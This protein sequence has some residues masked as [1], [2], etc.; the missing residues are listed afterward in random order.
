MILQR[1]LLYGLIAILVVAPL[2]FGSVQRGASLRL[3]A[4]CLL[5]GVVWMAWRT[6]AGLPPLPWRDPALAA[7]ALIALFAVFQIV[8]WPQ[9]V[10][11]TI[12][13]KAVSLREAY[14]P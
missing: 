4:G 10:L 7:G 2:P 9:P 12:S 13:P 14:E 6:R 3:C 5:L 1:I 8:P 11:Q